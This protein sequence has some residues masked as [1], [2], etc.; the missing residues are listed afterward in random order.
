MFHDNI[1]SIFSSAVQS[2][3]S[4][5]LDFAV[6]PEKD[7]TRRK[8]FPAD[9]LLAFLV[10]EG[11]FSTKKELLDFFDMDATSHRILLLINNAPNSNRKLS[12]QCP[13]SSTNPW[14]PWAPGRIIV[15]SQLMVPPR[16]FSAIHIFTG[17]VFCG[18][19]AFC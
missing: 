16:P 11:S 13:R 4:K 5:I 12:K 8:K 10:A 3:V 17:G 7:F 9:K 6:C 2:V 19:E 1:K 18:T 15:S 14:I